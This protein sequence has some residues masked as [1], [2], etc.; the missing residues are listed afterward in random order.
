[1][2]QFS[3]VCSNRFLHKKWKTEKD[4]QF[5]NLRRNGLSDL[6]NIFEQFLKNENVL[7]SPSVTNIC[8]GCLKQCLKRRDFTKYLGEND[9]TTIENKVGTVYFTKF[10]NSIQY[11]M[12]TYCPLSF[13][14][15]HI[16]SVSIL[17]FSL[18]MTRK[19]F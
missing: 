9:H 8:T 10:A 6:A 13:N 18:I 4:V 12:I 7:K 15:M 11:I 3:K 17:M 14:A 1:M 2:P 5:I 19:F 16:N